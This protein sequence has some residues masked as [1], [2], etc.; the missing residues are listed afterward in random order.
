MEIVI[1][2]DSVRISGYVNAVERDSK[3]LA[4]RSGRFIEKI[5]AGVFQRALERAEKSNYHVKVLLNHD[6]SRQLS[7]TSDPTTVLREDSIGL[8][9]D[10]ETNDPE[11][12]EKALAGKLKGWSFGFIPLKESKDDGE[13]PHREIRELELKEVS[14]LDDRK[15]PAYDGTSIE[16]RSEVDELIELRYMDDDVKIENRSVKD[17]KTKP[18]NH[19]WENRYMAT[20]IR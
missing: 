9:C 7:D 4:D 13:I 15:T 6:Y 14:I 17:P 10:L 12:R 2:D 16:T 19:V 1:R 20:K 18:D 8:R 3:V 11:I 5:K